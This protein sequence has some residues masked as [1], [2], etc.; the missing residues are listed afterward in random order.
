MYGELQVHSCYL[1]NPQ[2][3]VDCNF[4][5]AFQLMDLWLANEMEFEKNGITNEI[6]F[7]NTYAFFF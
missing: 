1:S 4:D 5:N 7:V 2:E 6:I 3:K